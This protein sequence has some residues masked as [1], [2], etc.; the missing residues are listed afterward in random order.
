MCSGAETTHE[1]PLLK[2]KDLSMFSL[3][4]NSDYDMVTTLKVLRSNKKAK[5]LILIV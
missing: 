4:T 1:I 3:V 5:E 2:L